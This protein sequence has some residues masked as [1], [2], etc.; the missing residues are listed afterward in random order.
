MTVQNSRVVADYSS[1]GNH[2]QRTR[3]S[4]PPAPTRRFKPETYFV[5]IVLFDTGVVAEGHAHGD[6]WNSTESSS[7]SDRRR[8][9]HARTALRLPPGSG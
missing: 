9:A 5:S 1:E 8:P 4:L 6:R 7:A 2:G 3:S